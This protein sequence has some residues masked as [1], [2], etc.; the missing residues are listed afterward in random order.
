M[1]GS[2]IAYF[3]I[4]TKKTYSLVGQV[5]LCVISQTRGKPENNM[6]IKGKTPVLRNS[7]KID[8]DLNINNPECLSF[9]RHLLSDNQ[10]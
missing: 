3:I 1:F 5:L 6:R 9:S 7:R 4:G 2:E 10:I 8:I